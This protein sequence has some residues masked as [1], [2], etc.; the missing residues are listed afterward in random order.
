MYHSLSPSATRLSIK[1]DFADAGEDLPMTI[2]WEDVGTEVFKVHDSSPR[3]H[4]LG[5]PAA[6]S[7]LDQSRCPSYD[8]LK[9]V[10][11]RICTAKLVQAFIACPSIHDGTCGAAKT[12]NE[13]MEE[14]IQQ[15]PEPVEK[16]SLLLGLCAELLHETTREQH[17][18]EEH[19]VKW[20]KSFHNRICLSTLLQKHCDSILNKGLTD[21]TSGLDAYGLQYQDLEWFSRAAMVSAVLKEYKQAGK[22]MSTELTRKLT[23]HV[24]RMIALAP[25]NPAGYE[26]MSYV[27]MKNTSTLQEAAMNMRKAMS[28]AGANGD[29]T[30]V[31]QY[32]LQCMY[33]MLWMHSMKPDSVE[34]RAE[35]R[36]EIQPLLEAA[37]SAETHSGLHPGSP[38]SGGA[39]SSHTRHD[40]SSGGVKHA[41]I[42]TRTKSSWQSLAR[43]RLQGSRLKLKQFALSMAEEMPR[44][45]LEELNLCLSPSQKTVNKQIS[46]SPSQLDQQTAAAANSGDITYFANAISSLPSARPAEAACDKS[47]VSAIHGSKP[48]SLSTQSTKL[49]A[50]KL[51][52]KCLSPLTLRLRSYRSSSRSRIDSGDHDGS[53]GLRLHQGSSG[54]AL[55]KGSSGSALEGSSR[56]AVKST[57][58][59]RAAYCSLHDQCVVS[60][61]R[62][63]VGISAPAPHTKHRFSPVMASARDCKAVVEADSGN[64]RTSMHGAVNKPKT[65]DTMTRSS[66]MWIG[67][68]AEAVVDA[69]CKN[70]TGAV[71]LSC[72]ALTAAGAAAAAASHGIVTPLLLPPAPAN[73][74]AASPGASPEAAAAAITSA[75]TASSAETV[76]SAP[77]VAD[78]CSATPSTGFIAAAP[79]SS[80]ST[81]PKKSAPSF[82]GLPKCMAGVPQHLAGVPE[83]VS[84]PSWGGQLA[85]QQAVSAGTK[86]SA[87]TPAAQVLAEAS[88]SLP[89]G[90]APWDVSSDRGGL[91][92]GQATAAAQAGCSTAPQAS[93][94]QKTPFTSSFID[95]AHM[96]AQALPTQAPTPQLSACHE[97][98]SDAPP[99]KASAAATSPAQ[100]ALQEAS[101]W[102]QAHGAATRVSQ[103]VASDRSYQQEH[104]SKALDM[105]HAFSSASEASTPLAAAAAAAAQLSEPPTTITQTV[106]SSLPFTASI[107]GNSQNGSQQSNMHTAPKKKSRASIFDFRAVFMAASRS[108]KK[109]CKASAAA[110]ASSIAVATG[111]VVSLEAIQAAAASIA[112]A[113]SVTPR[114]KVSVSSASLA[115]P[116]ASEATAGAADTPGLES[117]SS[118]ATQAAPQSSPQL[119]EPP[120]QAPQSAP[121]SAPL[122]QPQPALPPFHPPAIQAASQPSAASPKKAQTPSVL[123]K[124]TKAPLPF[125]RS[126][127]STEQASKGLGAPMRPAEP[128]IIAPACGSCSSSVAANQATSLRPAPAHTA[129]FEAAKASTFDFA[130][131]VTKTVGTPK[132]SLAAQGTAS[133]PR[134][135]AQETMPAETAALNAAWEAVNSLMTTSISAAET[136]PEIAA[137]TIERTKVK[138]KLDTAKRNSVMAGLEALK[139]AHQALDLECCSPGMYGQLEADF[140]SVSQHVDNLLDME[141]KPAGAADQIAAYQK[142]QANFQAIRLL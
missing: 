89:K 59:P 93:V 109:A 112:C 63:A 98:A 82:Q 71:K 73:A 101:D 123:K 128:S 133:L 105:L 142:A 44:D 129:V 68:S 58:G 136:E 126:V 31:M 130:K 115:L 95:A 66:V 113:S 22:S 10:D 108:T 94:A 121:L 75:A 8:T 138:A 60:D 111:Q 92:S 69:R 13:Q 91:A 119:S 100:S 52:G 86:S 41:Y 106:P 4:G 96:A 35:L 26:M 110:K 6:V 3:A 23:R 139:R 20:L 114:D 57:A 72:E 74:A 81:V 18:T 64:N 11:P 16:S 32:A 14:F 54:S 17:G 27:L 42:P 47:E 15:G 127:A 50:S 25:D 33:F 49:E 135:A 1:Q 88:V 131:A 84:E 29:N 24:K 67:N 122:L 79:Q 90:S 61:D 53:K 120:S 34:Q 51:H 124:A 118:A 78:E 39:D 125:S 56:D 83:P 117:H 55:H 70:A 141:N 2:K 21:I 99:T 65:S 9:A 38:D 37:Q 137:P 36:Q 107:A 43:R 134:A 77:V 28:A 97:S 102:S 87:S 7:L 30:G 5:L 45:L 116:S 46:A 104:A 12:C 140:D 19:M 40:L 103:M 85:L 80:V 62:A 132:A 76:A 48:N